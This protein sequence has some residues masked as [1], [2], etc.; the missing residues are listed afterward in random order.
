MKT[1][2]IKQTENP[3]LERDEFLFEIINETL[4]TKEEIIKE[5]GKNPELTVIQKVNNSFGKNSFTVKIYVY[6]NKE[7]KDKYTIISK[8]A[9]LKLVE[10]KKALEAELRKKKQQE[11][12]IKE[13]E[14]LQDGN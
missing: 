9:R 12:E 14:K 1:R 13:G 2:I 7:S 11:K 10:E 3:F 4:P 6:K 5:L 8:K